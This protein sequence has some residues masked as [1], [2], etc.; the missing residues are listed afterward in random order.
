MKFPRIAIFALCVLPLAV[1]AAN[2]VAPPAP[3]P[4]T[5]TYEV[6]RKG[7]TLG[8]STLTLRR[9][10]DGTWTCQSVLDA[11]SGLAAM[12][13]GHVD[14]TSRFRWH[15][16]RI[17]LLAYDYHMHVAFKNRQRHIAVDWQTGSVHVH[18]HDGDFQYAAQPGL[19]ERHLVVIA[20]G[21]AI[22]AGRTQVSLP[23]A[24]KDRV[25]TQTFAVR[26][27]TPVTVPAGTFQAVHVARTH[28]TKGYEAWYDPA[29]FGT[30]PV[31]VTQESGGDITLLLQSFKRP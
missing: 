11:R 5:A 1:L 23:V 16:G 12:L 17:E 8:T 31:K 21:Q 27:T 24:V 25:E 20:L 4:F 22:A 15:D 14:E 6:L 2:R 7:S 9:N 18:G 28:D 10:A 30:A 26:G 29:R 19:V 3:R 13:G